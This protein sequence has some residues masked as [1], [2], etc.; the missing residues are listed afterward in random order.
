MMLGTN[1]VLYHCN[2][3]RRCGFFIS[4]NNYLI[5]RVE[6]DIWLGN[7]M[8][9]WDNKSNADYWK[10]ERIKKANKE[11]KKRAFAIVAARV[12]VDK[13]LDLT[14]IDVC[15][16]MSA[17][18]DTYEKKVGFSVTQE[19]G[20]RLN[21][22]FR[23]FNEIEEAYNVIKVLG[24]YINTPSNDLFYYKIRSNLTEPFLAAKCIY[25]VKKYECILEKEYC[26]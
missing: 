8:Y 21:I 11:K 12:N 20:G 4:R 2:D 9:F 6:D 5:E 14:D 18:W 16:M 23:E 1:L 24:R 19:L 10:N 22:L 17:L 15:N 13:L 25:N 26:V 3:V 7:G